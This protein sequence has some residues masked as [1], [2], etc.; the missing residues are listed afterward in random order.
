MLS[1]SLLL[2]ENA[3]RSFSHLRAVLLLLPRAGRR[4]APAGRQDAVC[5]CVG[6]GF[7]GADQ[8]GGG[9]FETR[10]FRSFFR[11]SRPTQRAP[12]CLSLPYLPRMAGADLGLLLIL[13]LLVLGVL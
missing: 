1:L 8:V 10:V 4:Q 12:A 3:A 5:L 7:A 6:A 9:G 13:L 11:E 2:F